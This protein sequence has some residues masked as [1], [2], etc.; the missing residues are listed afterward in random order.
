MY[1]RCNAQNTSSR[2]DN[3]YSDYGTRNVQ[4]GAINIKHVTTTNNN[5]ANKNNTKVLPKINRVKSEK[6]KALSTK[7][8]AASNSTL[9]PRVFEVSD[10]SSL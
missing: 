10:S 5:T 9:P 2:N 4:E 6:I 1:N 7:G 8:N 3:I